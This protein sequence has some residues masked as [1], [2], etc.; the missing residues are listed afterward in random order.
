MLRWKNIHIHSYLWAIDYKNDLSL[1]FFYF[2]TS[3]YVYQLYIRL[4]W[5]Y[6]YSCPIIPTSQ[7]NL[8]ITKIIN[9]FFINQKFTSKQITQP[10]VYVNKNRTLFNNTTPNS[11]NR[12]HFHNLLKNTSNYANLKQNINSI[13]NLDHF[14]DQR[15]YMKVS[16][17]YSSVTKQRN[18]NS[19]S[20]QSRAI[21]AESTAIFPGAYK[22]F[23]LL[24]FLS[25][26]K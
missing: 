8:R 6:S 16:K 15:R 3:I 18:E 1:I 7:N 17:T 20:I 13:T 19:L 5:I 14:H 10:I 11:I 26:K 22:C 4:F 25:Q 24:F 9:Y 12:L 2:N 21:T 23:S